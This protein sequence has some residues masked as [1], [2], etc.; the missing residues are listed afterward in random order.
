MLDLATLSGLR[1]RRGYATWTEVGIPIEQHGVCG[2]GSTSTSRA[3]STGQRGEDLAG[4]SSISSA[5]L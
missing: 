3:N 4:A 5:G 2:S 1:G